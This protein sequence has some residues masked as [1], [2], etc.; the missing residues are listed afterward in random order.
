MPSAQPSA[1]SSATS[2]TTRRDF[3]Q[4]SALTFVGVGS[5]FV[6][7]P[8]LEQMNADAAARSLAV[9]EIDVSQLKQ[10]QAITVLW[11][12]KPV[13]IRHRTPAEIARSRRIDPDSMLDPLARNMALPENALATDVNRL[14]R[15]ESDWLVVLATCT[16]AGC[17]PR[18][19]VVEGTFDGWVC[20]CHFSTY[21]AAGRVTRGPAPRNLE[22][23][24]YRVVDGRRIVIG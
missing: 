23:P 14:A 4:V 2:G 16:H 1:Q 22:V 20:P 19:N 3:L 6:A 18:A 10:G 7:W 5:G 15:G 9:A 21:D 12:G 24:P 8:F 17:V 11:R 13:F